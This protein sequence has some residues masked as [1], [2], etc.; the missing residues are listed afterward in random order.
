[1]RLVWPDLSV[2]RPARP[3]SWA[4]LSHADSQFYLFPKPYSLI[5]L[6]S[7]TV[8]DCLVYDTGHPTIWPAM[9]FP[10]ITDIADMVSPQPPPPLF[11]LPIELRQDIYSHTLSQEPMSY[12]IPSLNIISVSHRPPTPSLLLVNS[13]LTADIEAYYFSKA[14][15]KFIV[16]HAFNYY[17]IDPQLSNLAS[18]HILRKLQRVELVLFFDGSLLRSYPSLGVDKMYHEVKRRATRFCEV[19]STAPD[20]VHVK[21]SWIDTTIDD[22]SGITSSWEEKASILEPL[23]LLKDKVTFSTGEMEWPAAPDAAD[24][25]TAVKEIL[26]DPPHARRA[27]HWI[28]SHSSALCRRIG[29]P[30]SLPQ[31]L[32]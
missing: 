28:H 2:S 14:T 6:L 5:L 31:L 3:L 19:L 10:H 32:A 15:F 26:D 25:R 30:S 23:A 27:G 18:S 4:I 29:A 17:R 13:H 9:T 8:R 21:V 22:G 16:S 24:F 11:L 7:H 1:M 20:L 12:P